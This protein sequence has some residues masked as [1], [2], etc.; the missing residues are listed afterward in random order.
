MS[1]LRQSPKHLFE[2]FLVFEV[3]ASGEGFGEPNLIFQYPDGGRRCSVGGPHV[4]VAAVGQFCLPY[5]PQEAASGSDLPWAMLKEQAFTF[6]LTDEHSCLQF[7]VCFQAE[8]TGVQRKSSRGGHRRTLSETPS[9]TSL[10][11]LLNPTAPSETDAAETPTPSSAA[12]CTPP[13]SPSVTTEELLPPKKL[14]AC[15]VSHYPWRDFFFDVVRDAMPMSLERRQ[16]FLHHLARKD[17]DFR[18]HQ[19]S[20]KKVRVHLDK[21]TDGGEGDFT[22]EVPNDTELPASQSPETER[23]C[24]L[25]GP[26]L[27][28]KAFCAMLMERRIIVMSKDLGTVTRCIYTLNDLLYPLS[29]QH[30]FIPMMPYHVKEVV[31]A[32]MPYVIGIHSSLRAEVV[33]LLE[34][35]DDGFV[36]VDCDKQTVESPFHDEKRIN[37]AWLRALTTAA[38]T[39]P[40]SK[41]REASGTIATGFA[42]LFVQSMGHIDKHLSEG[43]SG[44]QLDPGSFLQSVGEK[45]QPFLIDLMETQ[46]F[47]QF[48]Q[49]RCDRQS[50]AKDDGARSDLFAQLVARQAAERDA[51]NHHPEPR[52]RTSTF[53]KL[54]HRKT[55][56]KRFSGLSLDRFRPS[57]SRKTA[58][59]VE[60]A[61]ASTSA[62]STTSQSEDG[63]TYAEY[64]QSV[65]A[66]MEVT[67]RALEK[68][69]ATQTVKHS[70]VAMEYAQLVSRNQFVTRKVASYSPSAVSTD[71]IKIHGTLHDVEDTLAEIHDLRQSL[72][73]I[74]QQQVKINGSALSGVANL[75]AFWAVSQLDEGNEEVEAEELTSD[76]VVSQLAWLLDEAR[77]VGD[78]HDLALDRIAICVADVKRLLTKVERGL[79]LTVEDEED[80]G[81]GAGP[82]ERSRSRRYSASSTEVVFHIL[83]CTGACR[84]VP[85]QLSAVLVGTSG[86]T[87]EL[88]LS[89]TL[90]GGSLRLSSND[91]SFDGDEDADA[92]AATEEI[93]EVTSAFIGELTTIE[94]RAVIPPGADT[95]EFEWHL[96]ML[97]VSAGD[98]ATWTFPCTQPFSEADGLCHTL[99]A[100]GMGERR[101]TSTRRRTRGASMRLQGKDAAR[102]AA[103]KHKSILRAASLRPGRV[104]STDSSGT[105]LSDWK[106]EIPSSRDMRRKLKWDSLENHKET[107]ALLDDL[108]RTTGEL[109][110]SRPSSKAE[111]RANGALSASLR[112]EDSELLDITEED[113]GIP[114]RISSSGESATL[115]AE[116]R[117]ELLLQRDT[118]SVSFGCNIGTG[119]NDR[120][121]AFEIQPNTPAERCGLKERDEVITID[122]K[123]IVG[124]PH[125]E[126]LKLFAGKTEVQLEVCRVGGSTFEDLGLIPEYRASGDD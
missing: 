42:T 71:A 111:S 100:F 118:A 63:R 91:P 34:E 21:S 59:A 49:S 115:G 103:E 41:A 83:V 67:I 90:Q 36:L 68:E 14:I 33:A 43:E 97:Q 32:M 48:V 8:I 53:A 114:Q 88:P 117:L 65:I 69:L 110:Q 16:K 107:D 123:S 64:M 5:A 45:M 61:R 11:P 104:D 121:Y 75:K 47:L 106:G 76:K 93:F 60:K 6:S 94:L 54:F 51:A 108:H 2:A 44:M 1:R 99:T 125:A 87:D 35:D 116:E 112:S 109:E 50:R 3:E 40:T 120:T 10:M 25:L 119:V 57:S 84:G 101:G 27:M 31:C 7:A 105:A 95:S 113:L 98:G 4:D 126:V 58:I 20:G 81:D 77:H 78:S 22:Y 72:V 9:V 29:W 55:K 124:T 85:P 38:G 92:T 79:T 73:S 37:R 102:K 39:K 17:S 86:S 66:E 96:Q 74:T 26:N 70:S 82:A 122:G 18:F 62:V 12:S 89:N 80:P 52:G 30:T 28:V 19:L 24:Q 56:A 23:M 15:I 13:E 46:A